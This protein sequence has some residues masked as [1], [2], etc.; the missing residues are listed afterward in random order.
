MV[1]HVQNGVMMS[2][3]SI[4]Y[5]ASTIVKRETCQSQLV[6]IEGK[7][8][9]FL[10]IIIVTLHGCIFDHSTLA[11][12]DLR[13][14][15]VSPGTTVPDTDNQE[16]LSCSSQHRRRSDRNER[17][18]NETPVAVTDL[19]AGERGLFIQLCFTSSVHCGLLRW[20]L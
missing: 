11:I 17:L 3:T 5:K 7:T 9:H 15:C 4:T 19:T 2:T 20:V 12:C 6:N 10:I 13:V 8:I 16:S 1:V 14:P 18:Y